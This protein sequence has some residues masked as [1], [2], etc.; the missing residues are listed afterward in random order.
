M[1]RCN[2][3]LPNKSS[4]QVTLVGDARIHRGLDYGS[5]GGQQPAREKDTSLNQI[6]VGRRANF[7]RERPQQLVAT[8]PGEFCQF[9]Q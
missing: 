1:T 7:P 9:R 5:T 4:R 8:D 6:G 3:E 2:A